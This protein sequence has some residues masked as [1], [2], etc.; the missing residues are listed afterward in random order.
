M[1]SELAVAREPAPLPSFGRDSRQAE[2][3]GSFMVEKGKASGALT[4]GCGMREL[5]VRNK[6]WASY[7]IG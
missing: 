6:K 3:W 5:E 7:G 2:T 1:C 4:G